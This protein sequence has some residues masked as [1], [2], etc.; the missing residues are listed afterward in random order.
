MAQRLGVEV[1]GRHDQLGH[2]PLPEELAKG[3]SSALTASLACCCRSDVSCMPQ[4][5]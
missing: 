2:R 1:V 3:S 5:A 4:L